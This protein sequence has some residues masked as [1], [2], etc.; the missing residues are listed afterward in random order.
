MNTLSTNW[1]CRSRRKLRSSRGE[2]C[3]EDVPFKVS[4][5]LDSKKLPQM[6]RAARALG[7]PRAARDIC[8]AVLERVTAARP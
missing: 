6:A 8:T 7:Q 5:L 1:F 4:H 3:I 2:N